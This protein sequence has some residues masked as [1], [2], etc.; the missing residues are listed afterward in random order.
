MYIEHPFFIDGKY[1]AN[2]D[3]EMIEISKEVAYAMNNFRRNSVPKY[4]E[5]KN[6]QGEVIEK[7]LR[8]VPYSGYSDDEINYSV[9]TMPDPLCDVEEEAITSVCCEEVH[10]AIEKLTE[11]EKV[12]VRAVYFEDMTLDQVGSLLG[13]SYQ[14]VQWRLKA[15]HAKMKKQL[16]KFF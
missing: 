16:Q 14:A 6:E 13:I 15:I 1:Y 4:V 10:Q 9:E 8:E 3:N 5:V 11:I 12:I 2:I 7:W